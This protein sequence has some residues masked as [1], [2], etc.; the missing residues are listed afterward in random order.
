MLRDWPV[1]LI[2]IN[3]L[4]IIGVANIRHLSYIRLD[5]FF[6]TTLVERWSSEINTFHLPV[7]E[8]TITFQNIF[9]ILN[10][11]IDEDLLIARAYAEERYN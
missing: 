2:F 11:R 4:D 6:I 3:A 8:M 1:T 9:V 7:G 10:V 5:H